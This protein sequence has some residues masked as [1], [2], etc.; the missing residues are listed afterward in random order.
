MKLLHQLLLVLIS[1]RRHNL[2]SVYVTRSVV[3]GGLLQLYGNVRHH[4]DIID[5]MM[6][7]SSESGECRK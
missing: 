6:P 4:V 1:G 2:R 5:E 3:H 7:R